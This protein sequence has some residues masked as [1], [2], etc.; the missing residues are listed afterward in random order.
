M[1]FYSVSSLLLS[2]CS[3]FTQG[4]HHIQANMNAAAKEVQRLYPGRA[5]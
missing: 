3:L 5:L 1:K 4:G 2:L